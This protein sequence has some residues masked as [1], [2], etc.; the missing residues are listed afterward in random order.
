MEEFLFLLFIKFY[1]LNGIINILLP[2]KL[3]NNLFVW[4]S[5]VICSLI[6]SPFVPIAFYWGSNSQDNKSMKNEIK[7]G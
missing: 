5:L 3:V 1:N 2:N 6:N 4:I 7:Y